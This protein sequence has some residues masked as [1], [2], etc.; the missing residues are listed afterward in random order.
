MKVRNIVDEDFTNYKK[1]SMFISSVS[2]DWKC[3]REGNFPTTLCQNNNLCGGKIYEI[4][5]ESLFRRYSDNTITHAI[6]FGGLEW[7]I[8][9]DELYDFVRYI[10]QNNNNDDIVIY[11]GYN[12]NEIEE[13]I[14]KIER[15][16]NIIFKF[17]RY[18]PNQ[19]KHYDEVLGVYLASDNQYAERIS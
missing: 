7:M 3:C 2:C 9:F 11:T 15:F 6:V 8:Q 1:A 14:K 19:D 12:K 5:N 18:I 13:E 4:S 17:G 10:R 16:Y